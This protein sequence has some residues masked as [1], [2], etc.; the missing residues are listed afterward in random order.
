MQI[1]VSR[2][3]AQETD[4]HAYHESRFCHPSRSDMCRSHA[5]ADPLADWNPPPT[6]HRLT[7]RYNV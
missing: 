7:A 5:G 2:L 6:W 3:L 4:S 1:R